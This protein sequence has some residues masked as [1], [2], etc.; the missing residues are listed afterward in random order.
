MDWA[1]LLAGVLGLVTAVAGYMC[2]RLGRSLT[3]ERR[4]RE[5]LVQGIVMRAE[6]AEIRDH[7]PAASA[8][9]GVEVGASL[10]DVFSAALI[11][12]RE[13]ALVALDILVDRGL[14]MRLLVSDQSGSPWELVGQP[15]GGEIVITMHDASLMLTE[16]RKSQRR[17]SAREKVLEEGLFER[18]A[19]SA[20]LGSGAAIAWQRGGD[21]SVAW[22]AGSVASRAG[23]VIATQATGLINA[24][25]AQ[26]APDDTGVVRSRLEILP[27]GEVEPLP[28]QVLEVPDGDGSS[29][30]IATDATVAAQAERTLGRFVQT[31]TET[32]AHLTAGLAIFDRNQKLVLF[33]PA[34]AQLLQL[35]PAWLANRP[36][37]RDAIDAL[38]ENQ[39]IPETGD[40]HGWRRRLLGL[41][42]NTER[43][44]LDEIWHLADGTNIKVL[45]RPHPHGSLAFVFDDI[46][47]RIRLEQRYRQSIDLQEVTL[48][49]LQEGLAVFGTD[50]RLRILNAS[51]TRIF[52]ID[53]GL[54]QAGMHVQEVVR[55]VS[56]LTVETD[57]WD[58]VTAAITAEE[59]RAPWDGRLTLGSNRVLRLRAAP[60]P[61]GDTMV[62]VADVTDSERF[63][64]ALSERN[65]ALES[66]EEMRTAVLDQI[67]HRLR[68]P[69]NT[70]F[71][72]GQLLNDPRFGSLTER[73]REYA[74][75]ILEAS[76]Q[77]LDT[78]DEVT[79]LASL[80]PG[81]AADT[82]REPT[83]DE[84]VE[85]A[86]SLM[87]KRAGEAG[88]TLR[89]EL[90][91]GDVHVACDIG[92]LRQ[93][94]FNM[95]AG[96][97]QRAEPGSVV[98]LITAPPIGNTVTIS[99]YEIAREGGEVAEGG[100]LE[101]VPK[102]TTPIGRETASSLELTLRMVEANGGSFEY[103]PAGGAEPRLML[104]T[105]ELPLAIEDVEIEIEAMPA[106][107]AL[108]H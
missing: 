99:A 49:R 33:N 97:V 103:G 6:G 61:G 41:F 27:M 14:P 40:Y 38:R 55:L 65:S 28:L 42:E 4:R 39:R 100:A 102:G 94:A 90:G 89:T 56:G 21:G 98:R 93:I 24:R 12:G 75:G 57:L 53:A 45:A 54:I 13:E 44:D 76:G 31:M 72:F 82:M 58:R 26:P 71:G 3:D 47:D 2:I 18:R 10:F 34:F 43:A 101:A 74:A 8:L 15:R 95:A 83:L 69:L 50:G 85:L 70:I 17:I 96:A 92:T 7:S 62:V 46:S 105:A 48:N 107:R 104:A 22:S 32:F 1:A 36:S 16:L 88:V 86:R 9:P 66:A 63:A 59:T 77:L 84:T 52:G 81:D 29:I 79:D 80:Q 67:S 78:I 91:G 23:Q 68:T 87:E 11:D 5:D 25:E 35:D 73:Q 37:L 19:M 30:G 60:L 106:P 64:D 51:F 20:L 108:P